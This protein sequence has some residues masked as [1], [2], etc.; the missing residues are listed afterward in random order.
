MNGPAE[1]GAIVDSGRPPDRTGLAA[2][3][4]RIARSRFSLTS[5]CDFG[6]KWLV[7][8]R[9]EGIVVL[10][11]HLM[12]GVC[13][14]RRPALPCDRRK[15][16]SWRRDIGT[17]RMRWYALSLPGACWSRKLSMC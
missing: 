12:G 1:T 16:G 11:R 9:L 15:S 8:P 6:E 10:E 2:S 5:P 17:C 4:R 14:T 3:T 13:L 7:A